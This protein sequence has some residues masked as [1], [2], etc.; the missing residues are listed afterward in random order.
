MIPV[1][2]IT[3]PPTT[4]A[5]AKPSGPCCSSLDRAVRNSCQQFRSGG[6]KD[7]LANHPGYVPGRINHE[8]FLQ[9]EDGSLE[10]D[11]HVQNQTTSPDKTKGD[12]NDQQVASST[13]Q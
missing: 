1:T 4:E 11:Q 5:C 10:I 8:Y 12:M 6:H 7:H 3:T 13:H 2:T 9:K